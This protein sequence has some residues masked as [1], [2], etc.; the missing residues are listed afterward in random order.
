VTQNA[1][2]AQAIYIVARHIVAN[3]ADEPEWECWPE[4]GENDWE[5]VVKMVGE[6]APYPPHDKYK[7]AYDHLSARAQNDSSGGDS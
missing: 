3:L 4:I 7:A 1:E 6:L 2:Y 5:D